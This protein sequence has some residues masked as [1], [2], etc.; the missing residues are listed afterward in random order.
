MAITVKVKGLEKLRD[1][2]EN[3]FKGTFNASFNLLLAKKARDIIYKRTKSGRGVTDVGPRAQPARL[4]RL[5]TPYVERRK[6]TG[7][8]GPFGSPGKSN[9]TYSGQMLESIRVQANA[10]G[11]RVEIPNTR[12]A[13]SN[14]TNSRVAQYVQDN[15]RPFFA[16]TQDE[17]QILVREIEREV[18][19]LTRRKL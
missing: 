9:L 7:V 1:A 3:R 18:R 10:R 13:N 19:K 14:L 17:I 2:L 4:A 15:G 11:F 12:R 8:A 5:S 16:L 6:K